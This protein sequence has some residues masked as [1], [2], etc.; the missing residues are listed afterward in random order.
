M[1]FLTGLMHSV[2]VSF[3]MKKGIKF[4]SISHFI[5]FFYRLEM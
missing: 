1:I 3:R 4:H 5:I 2:G